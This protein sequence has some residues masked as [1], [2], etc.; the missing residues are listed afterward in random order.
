MTLRSDT[1]QLIKP[2]T[3]KV[4]S[5]GQASLTI[6]HNINGLIWQVFQIGFGLNVT[7]INAQVGSHWNGIPLTSSV[8]MQPVMFQGVPYA[9]ESFFFGPPYLALKAGDQ[10]VCSVINAVANDTFT[11]GA[12]ISEEQDMNTPTPWWGQ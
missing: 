3:T 1:I 12:F 5:N 8:L 6:S 7:A 4:G 2:F 10:V 11:A 9:M